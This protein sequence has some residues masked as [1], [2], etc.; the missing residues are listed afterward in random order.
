M[1]ER[2]VHADWESN[3]TTERAKV[4]EANKEY[5]IQNVL[6][7]WDSYKKANPGQFNWN[8]FKKNN[9]ILIDAHASAC[10]FKQTRKKL[11]EDLLKDFPRFERFYTDNLQNLNAEKSRYTSYWTEYDRHFSQGDP[12]GG[13]FE[14]PINFINSQLSLEKTSQRFSYFNDKN[15]HAGASFSVV[16]SD[17]SQ[18]FI[19][20]KNSDFNSVGVTILYSDNYYCQAVDD[21]YGSYPLTTLRDVNKAFFQS[22]KAAS[23]QNKLTDIFTEEDSNETKLIGHKKILFNPKVV[24]N[25]IQN[26][27]H[28]F[29]AQD[30]KFKNVSIEYPSLIVKSKNF[31]G[32]ASIASVE[33]V[34]LGLAVAT[35]ALALGLLTFG[36]GFL[37]CIAGG[38]VLGAAYGTHEAIKNPALPKKILSEW[39]DEPE[40]K[41]KP[42][43]LR[44]PKGRIIKNVSDLDSKNDIDIDPNDPY[45]QVTEDFLETKTLNSPKPKISKVNRDN[46]FEPMEEEHNPPSKEIK[47]K[48]VIHSSDFAL[49][50]KLT[51]KEKTRPNR[52]LT[53]PLSED[54]GVMRLPFPAESGSETPKHLGRSSSGGFFDHDTPGDET[55]VL[56]RSKSCP[57]FTS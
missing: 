49:A 14:T 6:A 48:G 13:P 8:V 51:M 5:P 45:Q 36:L 1:A 23:A 9:Q 50:P 17:P 15:E 54:K 4:F 30:I 24:R 18:F 33:G 19:S 37:A 34:A 47:N 2:N 38:L 56:T 35:I 32:Y 46:I 44:I 41:E 20:L 3:I 53:L 22:L 28:S 16:K 11:K 21:E 42:V 55:P 57:S 12:G 29:T 26:E 25:F 52:I 40:A 39:V 10:S 27:T 43:T 31:L 7:F